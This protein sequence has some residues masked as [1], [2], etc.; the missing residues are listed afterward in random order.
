M[1]NS[2]YQ[3]QLAISKPAG[4][5][6]QI[7][8]VTDSSS[9][10]SLLKQLRMRRADIFSKS[11]L[12]DET[13]IDIP[14]MVAIEH[15]FSSWDDFTTRTNLET[16]SDDELVVLI[17]IAAWLGFDEKVKEINHLRTNLLRDSLPV[18]LAL[19]EARLEM[20]GDLTEINAAIGP[21]ELAPL[22]QL[23]ASRFD[24]AN[25]ARAKHRVELAK[26]LLE[27]GADP[28]LGIAERES[29]RGYHTVLGAAIDC[30][31]SHEIAAALLS[32]GADIADG[33]T[34]Y[35]GSCMWA[36]IRHQDLPSLKDL[37]AKNPPEWHLAHALTHSL[38]YHNEAL[39]KELLSSGANPNWT[40][41][42]YGFQ[43]NALHEALMVGSA[44]AV[45][46]L[47]L[48]SKAN[49][50]TKDLGGRR[51]LDLA[52]VL[53]RNDVIK[54]LEKAGVK[55]DH[56]KASSR[57]IAAVL[58]HD[59]PIDDDARRQ[60]DYDVSEEDHVWLHALI[61]DADAD[62]ATQLLE[63]GLDPSRCDY[64]GQTALHLAIG[65]RFYDLSEA[66][67]KQYPDV[68]KTRNFDGAT[69]LDL[70]L[71]D[72]SERANKVI[73]SCAEIV[74]E[75]SLENSRYLAFKSATTADQFE[76]LVESL[77]N[78]SASDF[79]ARLSDRTVFADLRSRRPHRCTLLHYIGQNGVENEH[80]AVRGVIEAKLK[81]LLE[82][83][84]DPN[85]VCYT[86]RGGS[87]Q[88]TIAL[89]TSSNMGNDVIALTLV[90][91]L[92]AAGAFVDTTW[93][94]MSTLYDAYMNRN[95]DEVFPVVN[96][97]RQAT[98]SAFIYFVSMAQAPLVRLLLD[99]GIDVNF[100][101][102]NDVTPLHQAAFHGH[103]LL[104]DMLLEQGASLT[105]HDKMFNGT[106]V[107]WADAGGHQE[108]AK[109]LYEKSLA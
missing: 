14:D 99:L 86:Y 75:A 82:L 7:Q 13:D 59:N 79:A 53:G 74:V 24:V 72:D 102:L 65:Q 66:I 73:A 77:C 52:L 106:P 109:Y 21:L 9:S 81:T 89:L 100:R 30:L 8:K 4:I 38:Q 64:R 70:L 22:A 98:G 18:A 1:I 96:R 54:L 80:M 43:G 69:P 48:N 32:A 68:L 23:C 56:T 58:H 83:G 46:E 103:R 34:L 26:Y 51:P 33:P 91:H 88:N 95:L 61:E 62:S 41:T 11:V 42:V 67:L 105:I 17:L 92:V 16:K 12:K 94:T 2:F 101:D 19:G 31:Q 49:V 85:A 93:R 78:K 35:E 90:S 107:G 27:R 87:I 10:S 45:F 29:I 55:L 36:A 63:L 6:A 25:A 28:N 60:L 50:D 97:D 3:T 84:C 5:S 44:L 37:I 71:D 76:C 20:L 39:V 57:A 15:G 104:V 108:L 40:Q 47:L